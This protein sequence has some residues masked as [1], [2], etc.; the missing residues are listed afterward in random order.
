MGWRFERLSDGLGHKL[1]NWWASVLLSLLIT[2]TPVF[3]YLFRQWPEDVT[4][5][6]GI[7]VV[8]RLGEWLMILAVILVP[9]LIWHLSDLLGKSRIKSSWLSAIT[10]YRVL[11]A[12]LITF[13]LSIL[14]SVTSFLNDL[15]CP[16]VELPDGVFQFDGCGSW[17]PEW[18]LWLVRG[19]WFSICAVALLKLLTA[20]F[21]SFRKSD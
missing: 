7:F 3:Q 4:N 21:F 11:A 15:G 16:E 18:K 5:M 9:L 17:T 10:R 20:V 6:D 2:L 13:G 19:L 8:Y 1:A 14:L 12:L